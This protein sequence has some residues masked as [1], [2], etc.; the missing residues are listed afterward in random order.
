MLLLRQSYCGAPYGQAQLQY[1]QPMQR[2]ASINTIPS[3]RWKIAP[4]GQTSAQTARSQW[5]H[6][7][8]RL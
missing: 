7:I 1:L 4:V 5:L 8:D 6:A 2:S 3:S